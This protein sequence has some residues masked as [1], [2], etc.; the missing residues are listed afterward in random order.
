MAHDTSLR[1]LPPVW[2]QNLSIKKLSYSPT[3]PPPHAR[4]P[5]IRPRSRHATRIPPLQQ[6]EITIIANKAITRSR[7]ARAP[8]MGNTLNDTAALPPAPAA[9][10]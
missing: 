9:A 8:R 7:Q 3:K 4:A 6:L 2:I 5:D 1:S 10:R